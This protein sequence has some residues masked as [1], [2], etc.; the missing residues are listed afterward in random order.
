MN[1][2]EPIRSKELIEQMK[3]E[4]RK[5]GER[6]YL[7][8]LFGLNSGLRISD[9]LNLKVKDVINP[10]GVMNSHIELKEKKTRKY[11]KF[12]INQVLAEELFSYANNMNYEDYIFKSRNGNNQP[13]TRVQAYRI[14]NNVAKK[15]KIEQFGCHSMRKTFRIS[16]LQ[17]DKRCS[18]SSR[19]IQP[20]S[21]FCNSSLYWYKPR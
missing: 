2:V 20:F 10:Y 1:F 18:N 15:L 14:L 21:S 7:L 17:Y 19:I 6:N 13:I 12:K 8:F 11:K 9:I 3:V 4:L 16:L 5:T